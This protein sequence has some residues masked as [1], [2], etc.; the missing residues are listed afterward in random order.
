MSVTPGSSVKRPTTTQLFKK[1][2][3]EIKVGIKNPITIQT[4]GTPRGTIVRDSAGK[5][6]DGITNIDI[7]INAE[8]GYT[9]ATLT[10]INNADNLIQ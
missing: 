2:L 7:N 6:I 4:D 10:F 5:E 9:T 1:A 8:R 3:S